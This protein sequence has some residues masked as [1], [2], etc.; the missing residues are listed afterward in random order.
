M[1]SAAAQRRLS[2][3]RQRYRPDRVRL[4]FVGESPPASGRFFYNPDSG[5]YRAIRDTFR[6]IDPSITDDNFLQKFRASGCY[7]IDTCPNPVDRMQPRLRLAACL[8]GE[9]GL[10]RTI[11]R[12]QPEVIVSLVRSVQPIVSRASAEAGWTGRLIDLPYPGR[13]IRHREKFVAGL[14]PELR[15]LPGL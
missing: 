15:K 1:D 11:R 9:P 3:I 12:L 2:R 13:W 7:L 8:E 14:L 10:R 4:L 5:L 6:L